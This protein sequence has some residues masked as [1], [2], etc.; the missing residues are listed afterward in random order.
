MRGAL[1]SAPV[2]STSERELLATTYQREP[3]TLLARCVEYDRAERFRRA[4]AISLPLFAAALVSLPI[5]AWHLVAV[6]GFTIAAFVLGLRRL[7][8]ASALESLTGPCPACGAEQSF[9]ASGR[10]LLL[11]ATLRCPDCSEF[12]KLA[13]CDAD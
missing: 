3:A 9:A 7:R 2:S 11:P 13:S 8:Q 1:A 12:V 5:P 6:P 4:A 10:R